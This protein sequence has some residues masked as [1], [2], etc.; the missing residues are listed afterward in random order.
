MS[1]RKCMTAPP[2][3]VDCYWLKVHG[4]LGDIIWVYKKAVNF[5]KP[6]FISISEENRSRPRRS[7]FLVWG[8]IMSAIFRPDP[9][10]A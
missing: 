8:L 2:S 3:D 4:G 10:N 7:G 5:G 6:L 1:F 9:D